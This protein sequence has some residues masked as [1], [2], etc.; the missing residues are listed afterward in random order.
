MYPSIE[1][2]GGKGGTHQQMPLI[3]CLKRVRPLRG[4][5]SKNI[6]KTLLKYG[7]G[8]AG[9]GQDSIVP[10]VN[11]HLKFGITLTDNPDQAMVGGLDDAGRHTS[12]QLSMSPANWLSY[13]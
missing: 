2:A 13:H 12:E 8:Q 4:A 11:P 7:W 1:F 5:C 6:L 10:S 9:E 3:E